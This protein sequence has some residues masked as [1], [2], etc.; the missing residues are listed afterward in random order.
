MKI[1]TTHF[2]S[3][4]VIDKQGHPQNTHS[5]EINKVYK[6]ENKRNS[7]HRLAQKKNNF[8]FQLLKKNKFVRNEEK[9]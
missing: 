9:L 6:A 1:T 3:N 4:Y 5:N 8:S 2:T 7:L